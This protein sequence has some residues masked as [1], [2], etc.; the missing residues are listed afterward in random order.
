MERY[1]GEINNKI[2][3]QK[4]INRVLNLGHTESP[5]DPEDKEN[6]NETSGEETDILDESQELEK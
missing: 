4:S 1:N 2:F 3:F 6:G 5:E